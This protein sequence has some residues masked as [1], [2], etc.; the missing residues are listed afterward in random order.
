[1]SR[2]KGV[3]TKVVNELAKRLQ[4]AYAE[5][6]QIRQFSRDY[7]DL[8]IEEAYA[9]Q[10]AWVRLETA[11]GRV[12][13]GRKIGLTSRAMQMVSGIT[14][15]DYGVLF[16]DMYY[17]EGSDVPM[18]NFI[19]PRLEVELAFILGKP[20]SGPNC[21]IFDVLSATEYV[22]P[23]FE[24]IDSRLQRVDPDT[25]S[26]RKIIDTIS[27]NAAN[28]GIVLGGRPVRPH[29][30]DLRW[31]GA[32]LTKNGVIEETGLAA[33]VLN[34]PANGVAWLANK[35]HPHGV[36]LQAGEVVL[37]GSFTRFVMCNAGDTF[38]ADYGPLGSIAVRF[39]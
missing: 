22:V 3:R 28:G 12:P 10:S 8:S 11:R 38:H 24:I 33:G 37:G 23:A 27:D 2:N 32:I 16:A 20:L 19:E 4:G 39:V 1:M 5:R 30:V 26:T 29:D 31:V 6:R 15:P 34:H 18:K 14:E 35:L 7:P 17:P 9:V 36:T 13:K 21:S 25:G